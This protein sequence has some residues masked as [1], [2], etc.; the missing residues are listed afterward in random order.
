MKEWA[1]K[2]VEGSV[3]SYARERTSL[4][5]VLGRIRRAVESYG[6]NRGDVRA[7]IEVIQK[8]PV[9]LPALSVEEK[10]I[11]LI[12]LKEKLKEV[13]GSFTAIDL[14]CGAGGLTLG[15]KMASHRGFTFK[16]LAAVD[17][18]KRATETYKANHPEVEVICCDIRNESILEKLER[19]ISGHVDVIVGGPPCEAFSLAGKRDLNDPRA[20]LFYEYVKIVDRFKPY[21][22]VMENVKGIQSMLSIRE[23]ASEEENTDTPVEAESAEA[24][25][26][27]EVE[28]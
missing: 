2:W 14:F 3:L 4:N 16:I 20:K 6:V 5:V 23:D 13:N 11:K 8:S 25:E 1:L 28:A 18:W 26:A 17:N 10:S 21:M 15:F 7:I 22:F 19:A 9:Y 27:P 12:P 24:C